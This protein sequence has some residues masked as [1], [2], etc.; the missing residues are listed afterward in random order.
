MQGFITYTTNHAN[1]ALGFSVFVALFIHNIAEGFAMA[2]PL[3]LAMQSRTKA[4]IW[5][6]LLGGL[7]QPAGAVIAWL[8]IRGRDYD[9]NTAAYGIL[10]SITCTCNS[11]PLQLSIMAD[12]S[13][14]G[15]NVLGGA[16]T[17]FSSEPDPSWKSLDVYLCIYWHGF[18]GLLQRLEC[19]LSSCFVL[20]ISR[21]MVYYMD[22]CFFWLYCGR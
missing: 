20:Y 17:V 5:A 12:S 10:F 22:W 16:A 2:L 7:S 19:R 4:V 6:S 15:N 18:A 13:Y 14:S 9:L 3:F 21:C 11:F 1:P 8:T